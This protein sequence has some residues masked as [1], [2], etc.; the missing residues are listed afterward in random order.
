MGTG[1]TLFTFRLI[2]VFSLFTP[3]DTLS[4]YGRYCVFGL[5]TCVVGVGDNG[6]SARKWNELTGFAGFFVHLFASVVVLPLF[7]L[8]VQLGFLWSF[9]VCYL[10]VFLLRNFS[11]VRFPRLLL[12]LAHVN[13]LCLTLFTHWKTMM[14]H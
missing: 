14:L 1:V 11:S 2:F 9:S 7:S 5:F 10:E 6:V 12:L 3:F 4:T 8:S 13:Q